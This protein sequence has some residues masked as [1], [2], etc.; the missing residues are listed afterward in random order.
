M[1][2]MDPDVFATRVLNRVAKNE[3]IIVL[4]PKG[5]VAWLIN[6]FSPGLIMRL[7]RKVLKRVAAIVENDMTA[8]A[9]RDQG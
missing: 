1:N 2:P 8:R 6:R 7:R 9:E 5:R 3:A 4:P